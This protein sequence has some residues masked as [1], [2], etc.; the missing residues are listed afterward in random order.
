MKQK[1]N[2]TAIRSLYETAP[3]TLRGLTNPVFQE[4]LRFLMDEEMIRKADKLVTIILSEKPNTILVSETGAWPLAYI[5]QKILRQKNKGSDIKWQSIKCPREISKNYKSV[6]SSLLTGG[7]LKEK[8][9]NKKR[10]KHLQDEVDKLEKLF[11]DRYP[12]PLKKLLWSMTEKSVSHEIFNKILNGTKFS[13]KLSGKVIYLDEYV[14]SG[15]TLSNTLN[16]L[17]CFNGNIKLTVVSYHI[18]ESRKN[19]PQN[20]KSLH[21]QDQGVNAFIPGAY[22]YENRIDTIGHFYVPHGSTLEKVDMKKMAIKYKQKNIPAKKLDSFVNKVEDFVRTNKITEKIR[23]NIKTKDV[24]KFIND[25]IFIR[26]I[27]YLLEKNSSKDKDTKELMWNLFDMYGPSWSP[28]P[29]SYHLDFWNG[30]KNMEGE[31]EAM[32]DFKI[33]Q[34]GYSKNRKYILSE[35]TKIVYEKHKI[36]KNKINRLIKKIYE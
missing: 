28:M 25:E 19:L 35:I 31:I 15:T 13:K 14:H 27:L 21:T 22:P 6:I 23:K 20:V 5:C 1:T 34:T 8:I 9:N 36:W 3:D 4:N 17:K 32:D 18:F 26:Y 10:E 7:E 29:P 12:Y 11:T 33:I 16:L 2:K 24:S 30:L